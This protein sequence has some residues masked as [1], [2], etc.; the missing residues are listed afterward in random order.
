MENVGFLRPEAYLA[1]VIISDEDDCSAS[2]QDPDGIFAQDNPG[3]TISLRCA[4]RGHICNGQPI[5]NYDPTTGTGSGGF[6]TAYSNCA[7]KDSD[8]TGIN[9]LLPL[10]KV[11]D[12]VASVNAVKSDPQSQILVASII[13]WP[14]DSALAGVTVNTQ[15]QLGMD[16]TWT[17]M[18]AVDATRYDYVPICEIPTIQSSTG[19]IY[20]AY[21]GYRHK[22]F[23]D[24][25]GANGQVY[26]IWNSDFTGPMTQIGNA[27]A[28]A[29]KPGCVQYPLIDTDPTWPGV[30]P[31][32]QVSYN[33]SCNT[34]GSNGCL[35]DGYTRTPLPECIDPTTGHPLDPTTYPTA[36][37]PDSARPCWYL[38]YDPNPTTGCPD[39][40]MNQ[41][42]TALG[43]SGQPAPAGTLLGMKCLTCANA[44]QECP[45]L[46]TQ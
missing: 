46:G 9:G 37:I 15:Y 23:V 21:Y 11:S 26:S 41:R 27:I 17:G 40:Y 28:Q 38:Y 6:A 25:Y 19:N 35:A 18:F 4:A 39:A 1:I 10:I 16:P 33:T 42:I 32:C 12:I 24:A 44:G 2:P 14:P 30:Q 3:D 36:N 45:P 5:P 31:E 43:P 13:G 8:L 7:P 29:L 22:E 20:K 34:P